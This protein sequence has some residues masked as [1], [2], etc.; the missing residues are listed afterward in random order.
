[1][2][3][4]GGPSPCLPPASMVL[5]KLVG[6]NGHDDLARLIFDECGKRKYRAVSQAAEQAEKDQKSE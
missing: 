2:L 3:L 5:E 6:R 4:A 1:M